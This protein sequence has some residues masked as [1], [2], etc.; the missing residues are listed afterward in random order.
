MNNRVKNTLSLWTDRFSCSSHGWGCGA[1]APIE[2][3][4]HLGLADLLREVSVTAASPDGGLSVPPVLGLDH[5]TFS[6]TSFQFIFILFC[7][8]RALAVATAQ[9][10]QQAQQLLLL[11]E[12][13]IVE[14]AFYPSRNDSVPIRKDRQWYESSIT[15]SI[16]LCICLCQPEQPLLPSTAVSAL[17]NDAS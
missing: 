13:E 4:R 3:R 6:F 5:D 14:A 10:A 11:G 9:Q 1:E 2:P 16:A 15:R 17:A 7:S 8:C 12:T